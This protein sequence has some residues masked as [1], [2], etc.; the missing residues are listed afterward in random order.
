MKQRILS[1]LVLLFIIP[2]AFAA[3]GCADNPIASDGTP[4]PV[5]YLPTAI[6]YNDSN[7]PTAI[8][9]EYP[10]IRTGETTEYIQTITYTGSNATLISE[11]VAQE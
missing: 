3:A 6:A 2:N 10:A 4:L 11:W 8:S 5:C 7:Q 9:V 1:I